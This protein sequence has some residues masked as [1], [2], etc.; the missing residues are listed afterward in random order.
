MNKLEEIYDHKWEM[1]FFEL[2]KFKKKYGHCDVPQNQKKYNRLAAWCSNQRKWKKYRPL[3]YDPHRVKEL[4][5]IGF[6]WNVPDKRFEK[7]FKKI[8]VYILQYGHS[9]VFPS[10]DKSLN[11]W[12]THFREYKKNNSEVLTLERIKRLESIG[13]DWNP[14][15]NL[16]EEF[17][18]NER[19]DQL[20]EFVL[21]HNRYP[22]GNDRK[23]SFLATWVERQRHDKRYGSITKE[24]LKKLNEFDFNWE[25]R[26]ENWEN[27]FEKLKSFKGKYGHTTIPNSKSFKKYLSL[28]TWCSRQRVLYAEKNESLTNERIKKLKSIGFEWVYP[29]KYGE[30]VRSKTTNETL[31]NELKRLNKK[32]GR[33]PIMKD[34]KQYSK[35]RK[36]QYELRF[37]NFGNA[38]AQAGIQNKEEEFWLHHL[39]E[40]KTFIKVNNRLPFPSEVIYKSLTMWVTN[41]RQLKKRGQ[42]S[43]RRIHLLNEIDFPWNPQDTGW[44]GNFEKLKA[45]KK[46]FGHCNVPESP[47]EY[48]KLGAW[49]GVQRRYYARKVSSLTPER[50]KKLNSIGFNWKTSSKSN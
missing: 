10:R 41:Q 34:L 8:Q 7:N 45:Y 9:S 40:L 30:L 37:G 4:E 43:N 28:A 1:Q 26:E 23:Y 36:G 19:L 11:K 18:F 6:S 14:P 21:K 27:Q 15:E 32:L 33:T 5:S 29:L 50:I 47:G 48:E 13:F 35:Y 3:E 20:K 31:L 24:N 22:S 16:Y 2:K 49:A 25:P 42:L 38:L 44:D 46:E 12:C 17:H 39:T